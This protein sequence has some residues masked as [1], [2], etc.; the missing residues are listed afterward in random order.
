MLAQR[1]GM[2]FGLPA[3]TDQYRRTVGDLKTPAIG[4][5]ASAGPAL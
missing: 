2:A 5:L 1:A 4:A 3:A